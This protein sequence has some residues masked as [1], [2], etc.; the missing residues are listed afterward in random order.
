MFDLP[1]HPAIVHVP[2]GL[3]FVMPLLAVALAVGVGARR[4]PR[5]AWWLAVGLQLI[6]LAS[7][8]AALETG[9]EDEDRAEARVGE[10]AVERHEHA[11]EAFVAGSVVATAVLGAAALV[12]AGVLASVAAIAAPVV[13]AGTAWQAVV[14][15]HAGG[16]LV[17][18]PGGAASV[19]SAEDV[20]W[21]PDEDDDD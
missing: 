15:G 5:R 1:L 13:L 16:A 11:A 8:G 7:G 19:A 6:V 12:P 9:E 14:V 4:L 10:A 17:Y 18:G 21:R 2:L 3:A 20:A